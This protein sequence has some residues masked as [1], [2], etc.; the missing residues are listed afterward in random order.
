MPSLRSAAWTSVGKKILTGVTGLGLSLFVLLHLLG[1]LTYFD[2]DPNAINKYS[3]FL[4]EL[5]PIF[6][7]LEIVLL[8]SIILHIIL[9]ITIYVRRKKLRPVDYDISATRGGPSKKNFSSKTMIWTGIILL[10]FIVIHLQTFKWGP[11]VGEGYVATEAGEQLLVDGKPVKD[12]H[13]RI[14]EVFKKEGYVIGYVLVMIFLGFHL[15]HGIW[16]AFQS[17]GANNPKLS[18]IL[19]TVGGIFAVLIAFGFIFLPIYIY[20]FV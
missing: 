1:N 5:G 19:Y 14:T 18:P 16:S 11:G 12:V 8:V 13:T 3:H 4:H 7:I 10:I 15:R 20:F 6:Y 2:S 9:G 17:L